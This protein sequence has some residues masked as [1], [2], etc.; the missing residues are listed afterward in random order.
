MA[1]MGCTSLESIIVDGS[2]PFYAS[3]DGVLFSKNGQTIITYPAGKIA[4]TY[5]IPNSVTSIAPDAFIHCANL[6]G[7]TIPSSVTS[8]GDYAFYRCDNL[9]SVDMPTSVT[10]IGNMA[11]FGCGKLSRVTLSRRTQLGDNA[12]PSSTRVRRRLFS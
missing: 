9:A 2:N 8:V 4:T 10:Y 5:T 6:T 1:L 12:F 3:T 11:F 7:V